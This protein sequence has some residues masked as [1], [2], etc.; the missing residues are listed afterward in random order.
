MR[1]RIQI[2]LCC[3]YT[4]RQRVQGGA[5]SGLIIADEVL[6]NNRTPEREEQ[7][8]LFMVPQPLGHGDLLEAGTP[9][10]DLHS[11]NGRNGLMV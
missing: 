2:P 9:R 11:V 1:R 8:M 10:S 5:A 3:H 6:A 7:P 4:T